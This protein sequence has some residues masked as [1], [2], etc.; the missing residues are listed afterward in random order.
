MRPLKLIP[1]DD[2]EERWGMITMMMIW[3]QSYCLHITRIG[4][5]FQFNH[6]KEDLE[7]RSWWENIIMV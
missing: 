6:Q 1:Y 2:D 3:R 5:V 7:G 4:K